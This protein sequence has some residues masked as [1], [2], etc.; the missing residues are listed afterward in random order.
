MWNWRTFVSLFQVNNEG[1]SLEIVLISSDLAVNWI[2]YELISIYTL[3]VCINLYASVAG[4]FQIKRSIIHDNIYTF[5][6]INVYA[7][8][9]GLLPH[10]MSFIIISCWPV[11][12]G[13][14][15]YVFCSHTAGTSAN[16]YVYKFIY[17]Y[18]RIYVYI[19]PV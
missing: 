9:A 1:I 7:I 17:V 4:L 12:E 8:I 13:F 2:C 18:T 3:Y 16:V 15:H 19:T 6:H 10:G 14:C 11:N 5:I